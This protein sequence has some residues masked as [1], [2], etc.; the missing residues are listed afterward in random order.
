VFEPTPGCQD[1]LHRKDWSPAY[2]GR[3]K[4][5]TRSGRSSYGEDGS[6]NENLTTC[7]DYCID[8][9]FWAAAEPEPRSRDR[10]SLCRRW[11]SR[12]AQ[13]DSR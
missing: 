5:E 10:P 6:Y 4:T 3:Q 11:P 1:R 2:R 8:Y 12:G 7:I 9:F 13:E